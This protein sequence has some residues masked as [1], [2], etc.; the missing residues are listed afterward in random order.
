MAAYLVVDTLLDNPELYEQYKLKA[1]PLVEQYGGE[2]LAR[3]GAL[4]LKETA[5]WSPTRLVLVKFPD[6]A[7]AN[8]F[9]DSPEYQEV[10]KISQQSARRTVVLIEG[11]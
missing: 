6:V 9:Y 2:Y 4:T 8:R 3:G 10:L 11:I 7:T 5:L 1:K